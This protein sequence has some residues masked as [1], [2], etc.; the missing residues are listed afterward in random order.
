MPHYFELEDIGR[1]ARCSVSNLGG[2]IGAEF[3][4][5]AHSG[6]YVAEV[7]GIT[8]QGSPLQRRVNAAVDYA[9][10]NSVGSRGVMFGYVLRDDAVYRVHSLISWKRADDYFISTFGGKM[11]RVD[12]D[13]AIRLAG[14]MPVITPADLAEQNALTAAAAKPTAKP[15]TPRSNFGKKVPL[16]MSVLDAAKSRISYVFDNFDRIYLSFSGGKDSTVMFHLVADEARRRK[17]RIGVLVVDLEAQYRL[18]IEHIQSM[19]D[20]YA[21]VIDPYWVALPIALRNAVSQFDPKWLCWDPDRRDVWVRQPA[22]MSI[23]DPWEFPFFHAGMEFEE[24]VPAF[25]E[26]YSRG[27]LTAAFV[28]IRADESLNRWRTLVCEKTTFCGKRWTT[29]VTG[30]LYNAYPIYDWRTKD[31]WVY[32]GNTEKPYNTLYDLMHKAGLSLAQMRICQPYGDDQRRGLWLYHVIEPETWARVVNRVSGANSGALY[33]REHGRING[34]TR[35]TLPPGH[36]TWER[37]VLDFLL[38]SL[39]EKS[40]EHFKNKIA[41]FIAWNRARDYPDGIP[42]KGD[43]GLEAAR[44]IPSWYRIARA[45]LLNDYW[46]KSL[47]FSEQKSSGYD[48]YM[49]IM[50]ARRQRWGIFG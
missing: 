17:L 26:W 12:R 4:R 19:M 27:Q 49:K 39:P 2:I 25:G 48:R 24:F 33:C 30:P 37:Y 20:M 28:G 45:I 42:D 7:V 50:R 5:R 14:D 22:P 8:P 41:L 46:C 35:I 43:S 29:K 10:S 23:V 9:Q 18:T 44:K 6:P 36:D 11:N 13:E 31:I 15:N 3:H 47:S 16:G 1:H 32:H 40:A 38:P 34:R 21:D